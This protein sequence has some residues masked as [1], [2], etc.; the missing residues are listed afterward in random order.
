MA[1]NTDAAYLETV[2]GTVYGSS[3]RTMLDEETTLNLAHPLAAHILASYPPSRERSL[4]LTKLEEC[5]LWLHAA[6]MHTPHPRERKE[7]SDHA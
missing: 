7:G 2:F 6:R 1:N 4:A 5:L 3:E